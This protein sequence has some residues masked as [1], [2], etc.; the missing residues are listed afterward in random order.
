MDKIASLEQELGHL[1]LLAKGKE[2][3]L[4]LGENPAISYIKSSYRLLS[5]VYHP[6]LNPNN[7][8][9]ANLTQQ[10]LNMI[11]RL[12]DQMSDKE[13][14]SVFKKDATL[15]P[16]QRKK[17]ILVVEDEFGLQEI[18]S[19]IFLMEGYEVKVAIDGEVGYEMFCQF[20][21]DL[22]FTDVLMPKM[23]GLELVRKIRQVKPNIKVI[24]T[25]GFFGIDELRDELNQEI[26]KYNYPT[27]S[28]PF[29]L[30]AMLKIVDSYLSEKKTG[31][32]F[33][34]GI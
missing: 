8:N 6:D 25:S 16:F 21:P 31:K 23:N 18:L 3:Y 5:K 20:E 27:I 12:V 32:E 9:Q 2:I 11:S 7:K 15:K 33:V 4:E 10:R 24:F 19:N 22:L 28:K 26:I 1:G 29:K 30:S 14:V 13:I 34:R 17:K